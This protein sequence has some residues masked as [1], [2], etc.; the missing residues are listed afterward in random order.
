[1]LAPIFRLEQTETVLKVIVHA[2]MAKL[3]DL[4]VCV[5][6]NQFF[7][8]ATPYYLRFELP[9]PVFTEE[10]TFTVEFQDGDFVIGLKKM[11]SEYY[12]DLDL[13]SKLLNP[14]TKQSRPS[15]GLIEEFP[16]SITADVPTQESTLNWFSPSAYDLCDFID[17][18]Q[19]ET[20]ILLT[21]PC[22]G[23]CGSKSGLFQNESDLSYVVDL[24]YPDKVSPKKRSTLRLSEEKR[25]FSA[26]HYLADFFE[27]ESWQSLLKFRPPWR[28]ADALPH[29]PELTDEERHRLIFLSSRRLPHVSGDACE[30]VSLYLGLADLLLAH[31]YDLRVR[32]GEEMTESGWNIAK[33]SATLSWFE[34]FH[35]LPDLLITF[36]RRALVFPLV[37]SWRFC[38]RVRTDVAVLLQSEHAKSWCLKC[39]LEIRR[40]LIAYPGYH[41][42]TDL[43]LDDYIVWI[44]T[45]ASEDHLH[46]LGVELQKYNV[47]KEAVGLD[48]LD[49][50]QLGKRCLEAEQLTEGVG[51]LAVAGNV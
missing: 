8:T 45:R 14:S 48:L 42:Y 49:V 31:S 6:F 35:N 18:E 27:P 46:S 2:P 34:V 50:E 28:S 25:R 32:E 38:T 12:K 24:P 22:Y 21:P 13:I 10:E 41:V 30:V 36:Y 23:F 16:V 3:G 20:E 5:E 17:S 19:N 43:Y 47:R 4:E 40:L 37:R 11:K 29:G 44:Q 33:L 15:V 7:F 1:M 26:Q 39:L 51:R 9:G